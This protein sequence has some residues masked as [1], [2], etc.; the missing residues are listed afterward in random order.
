MKPSFSSLGLARRVPAWGWPTARIVLAIIFLIV[1]LRPVFRAPLI[2]DD[3][4]LFADWAARR[5]WTAWWA[6]LDPGVAFS[7]SRS[8]PLGRGL[9]D[10]WLEGIF[11]AADLLGI[12]PDVVWRAWRIIGITLGVGALALFLTAWRCERA[13]RWREQG[14]FAT[15]TT[16]LLLASLVVGAT[17]Q[18]HGLWSN[19]PVVSYVYPAWG[20]GVLAFLYLACMRGAISSRSRPRLWFG[21]IAGAVGIAGVWFYELFVPVV[22]VAALIVFAAAVTPLRRRAWGRVTHLA[23]AAG[24]TVV[25]PLLAFLAPRL[26]GSATTIGDPTYT[27]TVP[28]FGAQA[29]RALAGAV[30]SALPGASWAR[31]VDATGPFAGSD[32]LSLGLVLLLVV[33]FAMAWFLI[34]VGV[35][36]AS[37]VGVSER[38]EGATRSGLHAWWVPLCALVLLAV[39]TAGIQAITIKYQSE[40]GGEIGRV[41]TFY[42]PAMLAVSGIL[43]MGLGVTLSRRAVWPGVAALVLVGVFTTQQMAANIKLDAVLSSAASVNTGL[44]AAYGLPATPST[45][46]ARCAA[47]LAWRAHGWPPY[48][49]RDI[50]DSLARAYRVRT[51]KRLCPTLPSVPRLT[52][53]STP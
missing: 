9:T 20:T 5:N 17:V 19:D 16:W 35:T 7:A 40:L 10:G 36:S 33:L 34:R 3:L 15:W 52:A 26:V 6:G 18:I 46:G 51:G 42:A 8:V 24:L 21:A 39:G 44:V 25:L 50:E 12:A 41:Y 14:R 11:R 32:V 4:Y 1:A 2:A 22:L 43:A 27:G 29:M 23:L 30:A 53:Y 47:V 28:Q 37:P 49:G 48:Y 38:G 13:L 31:T 45:Q